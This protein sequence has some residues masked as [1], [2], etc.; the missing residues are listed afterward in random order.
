MDSSPRFSGFSALSVRITTGLYGWR[1]TDRLQKFHALSSLGRTYADLSHE[2]MQ[3]VTDL[4]TNGRI[5]NSIAVAVLQEGTGKGLISTAGSA[6]PIMEQPAGLDLGCAAPRHLSRLDWCG[7]NTRSRAS[8]ALSGTP[9]TRAFHSG[10]TPTRGVVGIT[11]RRGSTAAQFR[12][13]PPAAES[14][15][16][17]Y[18]RG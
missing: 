13:T 11:P 5:S 16:V 8:P 12:T 3:S 4:P 6:G 18:C 10:T 7:E 14:R 9:A 17:Y 2:T 1:G 15:G